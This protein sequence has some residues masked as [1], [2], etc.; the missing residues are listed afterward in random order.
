MKNAVLLLL[1]LGL[2]ALVS[3]SRE[4]ESTIVGSEVTYASDGTTIKGYLAY[5]ATKEGKRPGV[6]VVHE[7]WGLN[8]YSRTRARMLAG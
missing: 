2:L 3:C 4:R 8:D 7:W 1:A 6:L 5:D